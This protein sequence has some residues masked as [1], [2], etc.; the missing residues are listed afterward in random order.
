M[1]GISEDRQLTRDAGFRFQ[2]PSCDSKNLVDALRFKTT[3]KWLGFIT[4]WVTYETALKCLECLA[5]FRS[6]ID[7]DELTQLTPDQASGRFR[8]GIGL[9]EKFLV[10]VGWLLIVVG[11]LSFILFV[12]A[13]FMVPRA[14]RGWRR[15]AVVGLAV[16]AMITS[17][18]IMAVILAP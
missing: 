14:T 7:L 8:L 1:H 13:W 18:T 16:S 3:N 4:I 5:T 2:C 17:V 6:A 15:A 10:L 12:A 11:P 9:V